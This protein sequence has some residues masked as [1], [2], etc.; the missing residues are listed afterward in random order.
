MLRTSRTSIIMPKVLILVEFILHTEKCHQEADEAGGDDYDVE[1][2]QLY[3]SAVD[4][5]SDRRED[6]RKDSE[7]G[8]FGFEG[9]INQ[10]SG[11]N[12]QQSDVGEGGFGN[13]SRTFRAAFVEEIKNSVNE[14]DRQKRD[15]DEV[16]QH[17]VRI[18]G[19]EVGKHIIRSSLR[20]IREISGD[21]NKRHPEYCQEYLIINVEVEAICKGCERD[22]DEELPSRCGQK[23]VDRRIT[24]REEEGVD[25]IIEERAEKRDEEEA[26]KCAEAYLVCAGKKC[27]SV[28]DE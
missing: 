1:D 5:V 3:A 7:Y 21:L 10:K 12:G 6:E 23:A 18:V 2:L 16:Y 8:C 28:P 25:R 19:V 9:P 4:D 17:R 15:D 11:A 13:L 26:P 14:R 22:G 27:D 24:D 20:N